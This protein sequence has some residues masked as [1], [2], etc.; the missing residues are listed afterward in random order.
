LLFEFYWVFVF[1]MNVNSM[2]IC[3]LK[4]LCACVS[5]LGMLI[6]NMCF[7]DDSN[8]MCDMCIF[9]TFCVRWSK[10]DGWHLYVFVFT[11]F[12]VYG[13]QNLLC[14]HDCSN[15][16]GFSSICICNILC[17]M[18]NLMGDICIFLYLQYSL[19]RV[20]KICCVFMIVAM[21][22]V[23]YVNDKFKLK[24]IWNHKKTSYLNAFIP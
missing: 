10:F 16:C 24:R 17:G 4:C 2:L 6:F 11:K 5:P 22:V 13:Y 19:C 1:T 3:V 14:I 21:F 7:C 23:Y 9:A 8:F 12:F 18:I 15:V 20:I